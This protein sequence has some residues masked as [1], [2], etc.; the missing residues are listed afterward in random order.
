MSKSNSIYITETDYQ[1]LDAV[2]EKYSNYSQIDLLETELSRAEVVSDDEIPDN[3]VTL[4]SRARVY[5]EGTSKLRD[6]TIVLPDES[7]LG[8][9]RV[10]VLAPIGAAILGLSEGQVIEWPMPSGPNRRFKVI[11][12]LYQPEAKKK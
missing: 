7:L 9:G 10:S 8:D 11:K 12:V 6:V 2:A 5:D 1:V 3:V 4:H